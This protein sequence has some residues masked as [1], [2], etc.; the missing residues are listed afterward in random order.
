MRRTALPVALVSLAILLNLASPVPASASKLFAN[1]PLV[2]TMPIRAIDITELRALVNALRAVVPGPLAPFV[3]TDPNL[4]GVV[5]KGVHV[6]E[7]RT[8]LNEAFTAAGKP[9]P[10]YT[11]P[12]ITPGQTIIKAVHIT[13]VRSAII[14][15]DQ[16]VSGTIGLG[17]WHMGT[18]WAQLDPDVLNWGVQVGE[19]LPPG[20]ALRTD[21]PSFFPANVHA[22]V[23]GV[24][25]ETG[26][27]LFTLLKNGTPQKYRIRVVPMAFKDYFRAPD[28][29]VNAFYSYQLTAT[30]A[31]GPVTWAANPPASVPAGMTL[32]AT[33]LLSGTPTAAGNYQIN[34]T[35]TDTIGQNFSGI[36]LQV[37]A[38]RITTNGSLPNAT[39]GSPYTT[40]I[41]ASGGSGGYTFT[42]NGPPNG[43]TLNSSTGV[44]SG[45]TNQSATHWTFNVTATD[46]S[47]QSYNKPMS[48]D[49]LG[50]PMKLPALQ[51]AGSSFL[52]NF[53]DDCT[54]GQSCVL[55]TIVNSGGRAPFS[56]TANGLPPGMDSRTGSGLTTYYIQPENLEL[57]GAP[58][59]TGTFPTQLTVQDADGQ[60]ATNTFNVRVSP[61]ALTQ[62]L[63]S[64]NVGTPFSNYLRVIGGRL[65]Y[66]AAIVARR[67]PLGL[68]LDPNT[69]MVTGTPTEGGN[70][71]PVIEFTDADGMKL[72]VTN[73][74]S[75]GPFQNAVTV[76]TNFD[77]LGTITAGSF[78]SNQL[79]ACCVATTWSLNS[80]SGPLPSGLTLSAGGLLSG[81]PTVGT[82]PTFVFV[83]KA[84]DSSNPANFGIRQLTITV[85]PMSIASTNLPVGRV[86]TAYSGSIVVQG[87]TG[88]VTGAL[89][90]FQ[91][92]PPGLKFNS[93]GTITGTPTASG[94]FN[95]TARATDS[96][97][98]ILIRSFT[99]RI[100][101]AGID[102]PVDLIVGG[103]TFTTLIGGFM[104]P[105]QG[106]DG[107]QPPSP[108]TYSWTP[109]APQVPGLRVQT[110][111]P[112]PTNFTPLQTGGIL[113]V[114]TTPGSYP[115]SVRATDRNGGFIDRPLTF[116]VTPL[117]NVSLTFL[118]SA[119]VGVPYSFTFTPFG[120]S[121]YFWSAAN[122][123]AGLSFDT[124]TGTLSGT[125]TSAGPV[126]N[127]TITLMDNGVA[128]FDFER[129]ALNIDPFKI[130]AGA[131]GNGVLPNGTVG[132]AYNYQLT[133]DPVNCG[134]GCAWSFMN[135]AIPSGFTLSPAGFLSGTTN[136]AFVGSFQAQATG[137]AGTVVK[138]LSIRVVDPSQPALAIN[139]GATF[140]DTTI[141]NTQFIGL[142]ARGGTEP[143]TWLLDATSQDQ[144]PPGIAF[145]GP[146]ETLGFSPAP[147]ITYL[148]GRPLAAKLYTLTIAVTDSTVPVPQRVT[149]TFTWNVTP[150]QSLYNN[151]PIVNTTLKVGVP[152]NQPLLFTGGS[153]SYTYSVFSGVLPAGLTLNAATGVISG[154]PTTPGSVFPIIKAVDTLGNSL[155]QGMSFN[156]SP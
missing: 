38:V 40:T 135:G 13:E 78:Y 100:Y 85:T 46:S 114:F 75:I 55:Q 106:L 79:I 111:Q 121:S 57:W 109:A 146:G 112:L 47:M 4:S 76:F 148:A 6:I 99:I 68:T 98:N 73:Y 87:N 115:T 3:F 153:G 12:T 49:V 91:Y 96:A 27:Y 42:S 21:T 35:A 152:Y 123:P 10:V 65:P 45:T 25:T 51:P 90:P 113:G 92:M 37:F 134:S 17:V 19:S 119:T 105:L 71:S 86:G 18:L 24:P 130:V 142:F 62:Y 95:F 110:G 143:Y 128:G 80:G 150:L 107:A 69:L 132:V 104:T 14:F 93:D 81:T 154:T 140:P 108:Y 151:L 20:L 131:T 127:M 66:T 53:F 102:P 60:T 70:Y 22:G 63:Q 28:G 120:G 77:D 117:R 29:F 7:I 9:L 82:A 138:T 39:Q 124:A 122:V 129:P 147:G 74:M 15:L 36:Q 149:K 137:S 88:S 23:I 136:G 139:N 83:V 32:S 8:A 155:A 5:V 72:R 59:Q 126:N 1:D 26:T 89:E 67:L 101:P 48:I 34:F 43:L 118:P 97:G 58:L 144:L 41:A 44:I 33:G 2:A 133:T 11:D 145:R 156:V 141:G 94:Q 31:I 84:Q 54:L 61:M 50:V 16:Q 30:N 56:W 125:P 116:N 52:T 64:G 103:P